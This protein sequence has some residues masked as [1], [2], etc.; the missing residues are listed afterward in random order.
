MGKRWRVPKAKPNELKVT[1]G[2]ADGDVD[3]FYCHGG[4]GATRRDSKMLMQ[5]FEGFEYF[6]GRNLRQ[7][8][9]ERGYDI[10]T[11]KFSI[12]KKDDEV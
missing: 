12:M 10:A 11:L 4:E 3:L 7:E 1:Y 8:L 9:I 2:K 6:D 5:F